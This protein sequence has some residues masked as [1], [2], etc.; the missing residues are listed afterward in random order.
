M[1]PPTKLSLSKITNTLLVTGAS[2]EMGSALIRQLLN[3]SDLKIRAMVH[4]SLVNVS[5]CEIRPGNLKNK[6]LMVR[7]LYGV[8]TVIHMAALTKSTRESAYFEVNVSG[9]KNLIDACLE[10]G[11]KK[12]I[13][14]SS[15]AASLNGGGYSRSKLGAE[16]LIKKSG[17]K[18]LI[19]RPSEVYG[20]RVGDSINRLIRWIQRYIF[21]PVI[22]TGTCKLSPVF[23]DDVVSAIALS[24]FNK[25]LESETIVLAGPEELTYDDL[26]DR[27]AAY[28][29]VK[30]IKLHLPAGL[31]RFG[32]TVMAKLGM[33]ILVPD[34]ISRLLC[35]KSFNINLAKEKLDYSPRVLEEGIKNITASND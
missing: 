24:I 31:I 16:E 11:V 10:S 27:V 21:V 6:G 35:N 3:N 4:R 1:I 17:M 7:A 25:E 23:I 28:F 19:L 13:Y 9:T 15:W 32:I 33:D 8:D 29:G 34:Q 20:E 5:G 12:I 2:S 26:V 22:G 18:W 30:R 14:I